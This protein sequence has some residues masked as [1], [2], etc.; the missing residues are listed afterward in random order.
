MSS[1]AKSIPSSFELSQKSTK[2]DPSLSTSCQYKDRPEYDEVLAND[3][4]LDPNSRLVATRSNHSTDIS[5]VAK[6]SFSSGNYSPSARIPDGQT[7]SDGDHNSARKFTRDCL[8]DEYDYDSRSE[9][10]SEVSDNDTEYTPSNSC[11]D[12]Y[13]PSGFES[14][15]DNFGSLRN[16][17]SKASTI[18]S[19]KEKNYKQKDR[20]IH[21]SE[22]EIK[23]IR[24]LRPKT[25]I[26]KTDRNGE[27]SGKRPKTAAFPR[28]KRCPPIVKSVTK[29]QKDR[30]MVNNHQKNKA[31]QHQRN[32]KKAKLAKSEK[33]QT[34][35]RPKTSKPICQKPTHLSGNDPYRKSPYHKI[36]SS[37]S[38]PKRNFQIRVGGKFVNLVEDVVTQMSLLGDDDNDDVDRTSGPYPTSKPKKK[39]GVKPKH[40]KAPR[41]GGKKHQRVGKG[42]AT[43]SHSCPFKSSNGSNKM[44]MEQLSKWKNDYMRGLSMYIEDQLKQFDRSNSL[45]WNTLS[46]DRT[47][48][49]K[50][51]AKCS[52]RQS[53]LADPERKSCHTCEKKPVSMMKLKSMWSRP[54]TASRSGKVLPRLLMSIS[55]VPPVGSELHREHVQKEVKQR[56]RTL[57]LPRNSIKI[58]AASDIKLVCHTG[59]LIMV[60]EGTTSIS[61]LGS[62]Q[63]QNNFIVVKMFKLPY[64]GGRTKEIIDQSIL[65]NH[66][67]KTEDTPKFYGLVALDSMEATVAGVHDVAMAYK[68]I[69]HTPSCAVTSLSTLCEKASTSQMYRDPDADTRICQLNAVIIVKNII[70]AMNKVH[71][72][73]V[74]MPG[75]DSCKVR[76]TIGFSKIVF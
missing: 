1:Q 2:S 15:E 57:H 35:Q 69:G 3:P 66:V 45:T 24:K 21:S 23:N 71:Y 8:S 64:A 56:L 59:Q 61:V 52:P 41:G 10:D 44:L 53:I 26:H 16:A 58:L 42:A 75:L 18:S 43:S 47:H 25:A 48:K 28:G 63:S 27:R 31:I 20:E 34:P 17:T 29:T 33:Q 76:S 46:T 54:G 70:I 11:T 6:S 38:K 22:D 5:P 9:F 65:A 7:D 60:G 39:C 62:L 19:L 50:E 73:N 37:K 14:D 40:G 30:V 68:F 74:V 13:L 55:K 4:I 49:K 67:N 12:G 51:M 32:D 72:A 36:S